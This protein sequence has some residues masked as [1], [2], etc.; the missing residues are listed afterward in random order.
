MSEQKQS[1]FDRAGGLCEYCLSRADFSPSPFSVEHIQ[2]QHAGGAATLDNLALSCQG[3][4][5]HKFTSTEA[6]D[7][8]SGLVVPLFHPRRDLWREHFGWSEDFL[9]IFGRTPTGRAT[10]SKLRLNR[11]YVVNLRRVLRLDDKHPP[12]RFS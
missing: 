3:C 10:V 5:N 1:V 9:L 8:G 12:R 2:P 4:N 11:A 6:L 7:P